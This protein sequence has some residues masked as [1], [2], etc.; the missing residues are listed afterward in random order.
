MALLQNPKGRH[1][2]TAPLQKPV[3]GS[4]EHLYLPPTLQAP[5]DMLDRVAPVVKQL[6]EQLGPVAES[7]PV[8]GYTGN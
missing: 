6:A 3:K 5:L 8:L 1:C 4:K 2:K 7:S